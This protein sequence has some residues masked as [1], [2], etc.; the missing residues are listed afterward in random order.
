MELPKVGSADFVRSSHAGPKENVT[1]VSYSNK[2]KTKDSNSGPNSNSAG[3][4]IHRFVQNQATN[5]YVVSSNAQTSQCKKFNFRQFRKRS[6]SASRLDE[7]LK[8]SRISSVSQSN[9]VDLDDNISYKAS[10]ED[11]KNNNTP[12]NQS[13]SSDQVKLVGF[14]QC[15]SEF[16]NISPNKDSNPHPSDSTTRF[17]T[18]RTSREVKMERERLRQEKLHRLTQVSLIFLDFLAIPIQIAFFIFIHKTL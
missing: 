12:E 7:S 16:P 6:K 2:Y 9:L 13:N 5:N 15:N 14:T 3:G 18:L 11:R 4:Y 8:G 10:G 17:Q 1:L